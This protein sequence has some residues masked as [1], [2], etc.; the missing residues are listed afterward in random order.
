M[1]GPP[2]QPKVVAGLFCYEL[3]GDAVNLLLGEF[4]QYLISASDAYPTRTRSQ[5]RSARPGDIEPG[6]CYLPPRPT[7]ASKRIT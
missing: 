6:K 4:F 3:L 5:L 1:L 2:A 7:K